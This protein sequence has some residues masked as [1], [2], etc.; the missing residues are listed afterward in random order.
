MRS[1]RARASLGA[2]AVVGGALLVGAAAL[3]A[4]ARTSLTDNVREAAELRAEDIATALVEGAATTGDFAVEDQ[5]DGF[6]QVLAGDRVVA[7][8]ANV[9]GAPPVAVLT[10]EQSAVVDRAPVGEDRFVLAAVEVDTATGR[11]TVVV[12]RALDAIDE[13]TGALVVTLAVGLP[14]VLAVVG[15]VAWRLAGRILAPV[16]AMTATAR[17]LSADDPSGRLPEPDADDE[18]GRL[19]RTLNQL[20][21]R[22]ETGRRRLERFVADAAHELRNPVATVRQHAEVALAHPD[23]AVARELAEVVAV[24]AVRLQGLIDDLLLLAR[25]D[26]RAPVTTHRDVD[27]DDVITDVVRRLPDDA[28]SIID[29]SAVS[30]GQVHGDP[31]ALDRL[32]ANLVDNAVRHARSTVVLSLVTQGDTVVL[33]V[34]DDGP[35]IP[36]AERDRVFERF[37]RLDE[38]RDRGSGGSGLGLAIVA[39]VAGAHDAQVTLDEHPAGGAR[40]TVRFRSPSGGDP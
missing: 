39:A 9:A 37:V 8:S 27:L 40:F 7:S 26:E 13:I 12:G 28:R 31:G 14:L 16:A 38:A 34:G 3:V 18:L 30:G 1:L 23:R 2:V 10:D 25:T 5:E 29:R 33:V 22:L 6:I 4:L 17:R 11:R 20:L 24:E 15:L 35:G 21:D 36:P 19:A 32:V